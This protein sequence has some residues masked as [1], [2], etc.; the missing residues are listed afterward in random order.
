MARTEL[1]VSTRQL[2]TAALLLCGTTLAFS[3][4]AFAQQSDPA[5]AP[6]TVNPTAPPPPVA[7]DD[8]GIADIVVTARFRSETLQ[9][10]PVSVSALNSKILTNSVVTDMQSIQKYLPNVQLSRINYAGQA[11]GAS[12]RGISFADLEKTFDPAIGVAIDGVFLGT[13]TGANINFN[14]IEQIEVLRGPQG[15][16]YGRN[17][18]GGTISV[19][20][21]TPTGL[22]GVKA[23]AR[24]SSF[25][26]LDLEGIVNLPKIGDVLSVKLFGQRRRSD[27]S[28]RN[29]YTGDREPG[30]NYYSFGGTGL[31]DFGDTTIL[32]TAEYQKDRS[33][34]SSAVNLTLASGRS[35]FAGGNICDLTQIDFGLGD[36]GCASQGYLRQQ[37]EGYK[38][39]N[40]SIP[41]KSF[42]SG[43]NG[44][45]ELKSRIGE[46]NLTAITGY[47]DTKDS[48]LEE[49]TGT[50]PVSFSGVPGAGIPLFVA[51]RDQFYKQF[52]QEVRLQGDITDRIDLVAGGY[53]LHTKYGIKPLAFN[54]S[55]A[56]LAYLALPS[57]FAMIP[58]PPFFFN[59]PIQRATAGQT[60]DSYAVFAESIFKVTDTVRVTVGGRYTTETKKFNITQTAPAPFTAGGKKTWSD[61]S[62]R[63]II[64]WKPNPDTMLYASY[65]RGIRSGGWNGR[66]SSATAVGPYNPEYVDS[67]ETG[68]KASFLDGKLRINPTVFLAKYNDKQEEFLRRDPS[69]NATETVVQNASTAEVKGFEI[70][71]QARPIPD[72]TLRAAASYLDAKY[73]SFPIPN[74]ATPD[75]ID[76]IDISNIANFRRAPKYTMTTGADYTHRFDMQ[77]SLDLTITYAYISKYTTSPRVDTSGRNRDTIAGHTNFDISLALTH[78]TDG[79]QS[80][81]IAAYAKDLFHGGNRL[82]NTL[83][84]GVFYFGAVNPNRELGVEATVRF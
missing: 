26:S 33:R 11:L 22:F 83:D 50:P 69:G 32:A 75:P 46:F 73:K 44:S 9:N 8:G 3:N 47:R 29:R 54:G 59:A 82:T 40:T 27:S 41:F 71:I 24:Y 31:F 81:R 34:Y 16:L 70:D 57:F 35:F 64:D 1:S 13:N 17:T 18:I 28:T 66:A 76:T 63:A 72:L 67:F 78:K 79:G 52:S 43:W 53:Y 5:T 61:P 56:G 21:T 7:A 30:R 10:T 80:L 4:A 62:G 77:N 15:T 14:D 36:L 60:L 23:T 84:A 25:N 49:N 37:G 65:S 74:L 6:P 55:T 39:A 20:R 2:R 42:L 68:V 38:L 58:G 51:A 45:L 19:R 12:I 48:L